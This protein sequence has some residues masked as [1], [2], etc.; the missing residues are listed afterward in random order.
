L[1]TAPTIESTTLETAFEHIGAESAVWLRMAAV[2]GE[3]GGWTA[4]PVE[5]T[6][7]SWPPSWEQRTWEYPDALFVA[8]V[9][10]GRD[11]VAA[12]R[13][14]SLCVGEHAIALPELTPT[15][16]WDRRQSHSP[17]VFE[18]LEW[19]STETQ[20]STL[21]GNSP[22]PQGHMLSGNDAPSFVS[23]YAAA[24]YFFLLHQKP[25]GGQMQQ[26]LW[27]RHQDFRG[28]INRVRIGHDAVE[29]EVEGLGLDGL[30]MELPGEA[31]GPSTRIWRQY[32]TEPEVIQFPLKDR[33]PA[34]SWVLLRNGAEWIDRRFLAFPYAR[35]NEAGVEIVVEPGTRLESLVASRERQTV[36][37]KRQLPRDDESKA[38]VM[39]T[40]C[41][42]ANGDGGSLL[43][44]VDDD[45]NL[46]GLDEA[47]IDKMRDQVTQMIGSWVEPRPISSF[48]VLPISD[49]A[50]L[51]LELQV[52][53]GTDL[54]GSGRPGEVRT[55]YV[56]H[57]GI[58]ERATP[59]EIAAIVHARSGGRTQQIPW[60]YQ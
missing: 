11:I 15:P 56:R 28:R 46:V 25:I 20:L 18:A 10:S 45:R 53:A 51:V 44:G 31:P 26:G 40:V 52:Q 47:A 35:G 33:L 2:R 27:Y 38:K 50:K 30:V 13:A 60:A 23:F 24:A 57:N 36:E 43:I 42:F 4:G 58:T 8:D 5:L 9:R 17:G 1:V 59:A 22:Q 21:T 29:V 37:F 3:E 32:G 16:R 19:P 34:E 6:S 7:G 49:S 12:L 48:V 39:K 14:G 54:Y 55:V 41:A